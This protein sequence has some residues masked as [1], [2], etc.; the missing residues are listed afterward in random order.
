MPITQELRDLAGEFANA[1]DRAF[2]NDPALA[3]FREWLGARGKSCYMRWLITDPVR[4][5]GESLREFGALIAFTKVD[6]FFSRRYAPLLPW[7]VERILYPTHFTLFL[8]LALTLAA[9]VAVWK[10]SWQANPLW[11]AFI[12]LCLPIL[13]HLFITWHGDAMAPERHALSVGLQLVLSLWILILLVGDQIAARTIRQ[14][15]E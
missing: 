15:I 8:W 10:K 14:R 7:R 1:N 2:Y 5:G 4:S 12:L 6:S 3:N 13:P 11:A 9:C